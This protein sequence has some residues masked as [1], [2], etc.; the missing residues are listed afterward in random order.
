[1]SSVNL[2]HH[3]AIHRQYLSRDVSCSRAGQDKA[4]S[5]MSSGWP[6]AFSGIRLINSAR[7]GSVSAAVISVSMNPGASAL[8]VMPRDP[9][10]R[11]TDFVKPINAAL[12]AA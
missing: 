9:N 1:V 11:A 3:A 4:A 5:A 7:I 8:H 12:L 6:R 2:H 10:S